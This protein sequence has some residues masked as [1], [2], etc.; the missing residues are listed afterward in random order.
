MTNPELAPD[1][2]K[3]IWAN[4]SGRKEDGSCNTGTWSAF[5][6][7][8]AGPYATPSSA[9]QKYKRT[10]YIRADLA[11]QAGSVDVE[12]VIDAVTSFY[13]RKEDRNFAAQVARNTLDNLLAGAPVAGDERPAIPGLQEELETLQQ[14]AVDAFRAEI[15]KKSSDSI[16][17]FEDVAV[18]WTVKH[19]LSLSPRPAIPG[20]QEAI[21]NCSRA[22]THRDPKSL[23]DGMLFVFRENLQLLIEAARHYKKPCEI[24]D[25]TGVV[26]TTDKDHEGQPIEARCP[27][28]QAARDGRD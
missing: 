22:P 9:P 3:Q 8:R 25:G 16:N 26:C 21:E 1:M 14:Q 23:N 15:Q 18:R 6:T 12:A 5:D 19:M 10:P 4:D 11:P 28:Q 17:L 20:L 7:P 24:C 2:P 13:T 27:C